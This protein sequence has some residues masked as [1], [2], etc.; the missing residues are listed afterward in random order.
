MKDHSKF[1]SGFV[2][3]SLFSKCNT[4]SYFYKN[5][6]SNSN[7]RNVVLFKKKLSVRKNRKKVD[8]PKFQYGSEISEAVRTRN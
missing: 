3:V 1:F 4:R 6:K 8:F 2:N 7:A 5:N